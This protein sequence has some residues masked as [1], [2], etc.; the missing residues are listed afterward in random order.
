MINTRWVHL[1]DQFLPD[2]ALQWLIWSMCVVNFVKPELWSQI[3]VCMRFWARDSPQDRVGIR[4]TSIHPS[5]ICTS[6][7]KPSPLEINRFERPVRVG[8]LYLTT[9]FSVDLGSTVEE[10]T[11]RELIPETAMT[12]MKYILLIAISIILSWTCWKWKYQ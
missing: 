9:S 3:L 5:P 1:F 6:P 8:G 7:Y 10:T 12:F 2:V 4:F 11:S